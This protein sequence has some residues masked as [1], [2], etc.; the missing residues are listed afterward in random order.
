MEE[1]TLSLNGSKVTG[2]PGITILDLAQQNGI[3]IPTLCHDPHL[4]PV[5]ACRVCLVENE[6]TGAL[7]AS[8]VTPIA[9]GMV[10]N[11][12]SPKALEARRTVVELLLASHPDSCIICDKGNRCQL[13]KIASDLEIG[14]VR[15]S[16]TRHYYPIED[17]NPFLERDLS[18]CILCGKCIR[19]CQ[20][21]QGAGA[22]D[23]A[24]RGFD[25]KP[26]TSLEVP[27]EQS[28]C[29]FCGLC[30][31]LCPTGALSEKMRKYKG[32]ETKRVRTICPFCGCG[33]GIYLELRDQEVIGVSADA[34]NPVN[35]I[36]LC[37]KGRYGYD[38]IN[39]EDR[40]KKPLIRK[41]GKLEEASWEEALDLVA[42]KL[43]QIRGESGADSIACLSSA[44]STNEENYLLQKFTR[45]VIRTNNIDHCARLCHSVTVAGLATSFGSG[46]MTNSIAEIEDAD[47][48]LITGSNTTETH[49]IIALRVRRA[50][51]KG[52]KLIV[53]DPRKIDIIKYATLWLR[54]NPG[55]DVA[56]LNGLMHIIIEEGLW[57]K[58]YVE[59]R[60]EK[61]EA[62]RETV[63]KYTPD[64]VEAISGIPEDRLREAAHIYASGERATI[65]FAMGITQHT[66]GTDNVKSIANLAMLC[67]NVGIESGGVNPLRGQ[68]NVQGACDMGALPNLLPGYQG[69][70]DEKAVKR[71]EEAWGKKLPTNP[72][73]TVVEMMRAAEEGKIRAMY[74]MG[75]NPMISDPDLKHVEAAL[76]KLDFLVVQ[77]IFLTETA[78]LAHVVL[79]S[80]TFAEKEGTFTNTER[81]VQRIREAIEPIGEAKPDWQI[82]CQLAS[83]MGYEM[84]YEHPSQIMEEIAKL[85]PIYGGIY[86]DRLEKEGLQWPCPNREHPGTRYLHKDRFTRGLGLFQAVEYIPPA[87]T[88]DEDYPYILST[89]RVL[90]H[91]HTGSMTRRCQGLAEIYP[92]ALAEINP[93]DAR[94]LGVEDGEMVRI[95][96]RRGEV[97]VKAKVTERAPKGVVF[98]NFH[99]NEA[100]VNMLTNPALDPVGKIPEYKV[101]AVRVEKA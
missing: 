37:V 89:G 14:Q 11:T 87:E 61:F 69:V 81:M 53:I 17:T 75:E 65:L 29:E 16:K 82:I 6:A 92:E 26:A 72:G 55:T 34:E 52:A 20:E 9:P 30:V 96:S 24:Y 93:S 80:V 70:S 58:D 38:F 19:G 88:P 1:I 90:Y 64:F 76:K 67:G 40:L 27:L 91:Y 12:E 59:T 8:C 18:K 49:P 79:P 73:L 50:V 95:A 45:A 83:R 99:F 32:R 15:F 35:R 68:N 25:S 78:Q 42:S 3:H 100:A 56:W 62:L 21:L 39:H 10:I 47:V 98:M 86:Y 71:F 41:N 23:Y 22:I 44:K 33:C 60:T 13:R 74:I 51:M 57:D 54:Q 48:I 2:R 77:D 63:K 43:E 31:S 4:T 94:D 84:N 97:E 28:S 66:T 7:L 101:C 46:A 5:G 85:T 36:S